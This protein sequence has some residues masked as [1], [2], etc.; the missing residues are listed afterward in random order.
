MKKLLSG[1]FAV[2][3]LAFAAAAYAAPILPEV[4]APNYQPG[5]DGTQWG[6]EA[7][8]GW[9]TGEEG[10]LPAVQGNTIES[11]KFEDQPGLNGGFLFIPP[12]PHCAVGPSHL[13]TIVNCSI[14]WYAKTGGAAQNIQPLGKQRRGLE[15]V[16]QLGPRSTPC[17]TKVI[18]DQYNNRFLAGA[19]AVG[20]ATATRLVRRFD[21]SDRVA[22]AGA[23]NPNWSSPV[24]TCGSLSGPAR[25][26]TAFYVTGKRFSYPASSGVLAWIFPKARSTLEA[27]SP[28]GGTAFN[29]AALAAD[30]PEHWHGVQQHDDA[31]SDV[32]HR[33]RRRHLARHVFGPLDGTN[34]YL[35]HPGG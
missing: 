15:R 34:E 28:P 12:D 30:L 4:D 18:Y 27:P 7:P 31:G 21:D 19:R 11:V 26:A 8:V 3:I 2:S 17:L 22:P 9:N 14:Q 10:E 6:M 1:F 33:P 29:A 16:L 35:N 32:R 20:G 24:W 23:I 5:I 13:V 25:D